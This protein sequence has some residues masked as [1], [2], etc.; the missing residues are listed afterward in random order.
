MSH[1]LKHY[2]LPIVA[3]VATPSGMMED[4]SIAEE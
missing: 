3:T 4:R 2:V 1:P